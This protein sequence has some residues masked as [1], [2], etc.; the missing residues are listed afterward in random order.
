MPDRPKSA[1]WFPKSCLTAI[2]L[3]STLACTRPNDAATADSAAETTSVVTP[4]E[5]AC[6]E[7]AQNLRALPSGRVE[8]FTDSF[9]AFVGP[10]RRYGCVIRAYGPLR[11]PVTVGYLGGAI[12]DS[13]GPAWHPDS[14]VQAD[15]PN[16]A[17]YALWRDD[18]LCLFRINWNSSDV[19]IPLAEQELQYVGEIGCEQLPDRT[20]P[21][22]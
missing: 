12:A 2:A 7:I 6:N 4:L 22:L 3:A 11:E 16:G 21:R 1:P 18:V 15:G 5:T 13:L 17:I 19:A 8:Q 20:I 14:S 10:M 9:P